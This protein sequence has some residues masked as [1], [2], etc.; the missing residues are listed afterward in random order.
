VARN[1]ADRWR[2]ADDGMH[3]IAAGLYGLLRQDRWVEKGGSIERW[4]AQHVRRRVRV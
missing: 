1:P 2:K 3:V 4:L